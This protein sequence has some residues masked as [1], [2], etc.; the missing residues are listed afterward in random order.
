LSA[1]QRTNWLTGAPLRKKLQQPESVAWAGQPLR[2]ALEGFSHAQK[3]AVLLDRR[4]DPGQP[5]EASLANTPVGEILTSVAATRGLGVSFFESLV[6]LGPPAT[7]QRLRTI[8]ELR[9]AELSQPS[10]A[11]RLLWLQV[12]P[13][14]WDSFATPRDLL[15]QLAKEGRFEIKGLEMIPHDLW[16]AADLPPL[17]MTDR[18]T[19]VLAQFDCTYRLLPA[20]AAIQLER[21]PAEVWLD[22]SYAGGSKPEELAERFIAALPGATVR[23]TDGKVLVRG[24]AEHHEQIAAGLIRAFKPPAGG[25]APLDRKISLTATNQS[26]KT[27]LDSL[28]KQF[29]L[30]LKIDAG[31]LRQSGRSLDM[32]VSV[33]LKNASLDETLAAVLSPARLTFQRSG[34]TVEIGAE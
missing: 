22:R 4:I 33:T 30:E 28:Q 3:V 2:D 11:L 16:A 10:N 14:R 1:A 19:L 31:K 21:M 27:I 9:K 25:E 24:L 7:A 26:I 32:L 6:Y 13:F 15:G 12:R 17:A 20:G 5:L 18:L 23:V 8:G 34:K 29:G